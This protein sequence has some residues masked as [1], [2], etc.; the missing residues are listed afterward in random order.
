MKIFITLTHIYIQNICNIYFFSKEN[1]KEHFC[2]DLT[3]NSLK[4]NVENLIMATLKRKIKVRKGQ[5]NHAQKS[6]NDIDQNLDDRV[7]IKPLI[8]S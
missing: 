8:N 1:S 3:I 2:K 4:I 7:K 6:L 5:R